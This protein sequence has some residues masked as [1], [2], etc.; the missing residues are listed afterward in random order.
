MTTLTLWIVLTTCMTF[1]GEAK[2]SYAVFSTK[3]AAAHFAEPDVDAVE[4]NCK[5]SV[6]EASAQKV[7][8]EPVEPELSE[9]PQFID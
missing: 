6:Y 9:P 2:Q 3:D 1:G 4:S 5:A 7:E 8:P